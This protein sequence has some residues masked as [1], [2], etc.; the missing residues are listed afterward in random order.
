MKP[1]KLSLRG[2]VIFK[3][4]GETYLMQMFFTAAYCLMNA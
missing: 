2:F 1:R 4:S 3:M